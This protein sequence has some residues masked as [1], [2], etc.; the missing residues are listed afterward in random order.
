MTTA[1]DK[2]TA[3]IL[4]IAH[5]LGLALSAALLW[6]DRLVGLWPKVHL[7][8]LALLAVTAVWW[9]WQWNLL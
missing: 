9:L 5:R 7:S 6:R 2:G 1:N 3:T 4:A 8:F